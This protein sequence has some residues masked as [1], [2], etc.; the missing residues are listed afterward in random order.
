MNRKKTK[1]IEIYPG[2]YCAT[3]LE[4]HKSDEENIIAYFEC[5]FGDDITTIKVASFKELEEYCYYHKFTKKF[6]LDTIKKRIKIKSNMNLETWI[7]VDNGDMFEGTREQFMNC[8][9]SNAD[10]E[11]IKS[12]CLKNGYSL[13]IG[14][15]TIFA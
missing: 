14:E 13:K 10:D 11:Q 4:E 5:L 2:K 15:E 9:F 3:P 7:L 12:W 6:V 8:F 1:A